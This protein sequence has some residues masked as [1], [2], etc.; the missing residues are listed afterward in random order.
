MD[1]V[2]FIPYQD[3]EDLIYS[4]NAGDVQWVVN[5]K[6]IKG[7]S[8]PS[9]L[10]GCASGAKPVLGV[11]EK[12]S[13][14]RLLIEE[15]GCGLVSEP[16]EYDKVEENIKWFIQNAGSSKIVEMG[17]NGREYLLKNLTKEESVQ[18]YK[19]AIKGL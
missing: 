3:K 13:E 10:Y 1:N 6:G 19:E 9:K 14:A 17:K 11:L 7:V 5:S 12:G 4:L 2:V 15:T 16:E 18:K 8:C